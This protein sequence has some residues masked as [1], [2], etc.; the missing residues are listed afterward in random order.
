MD[1]LDLTT[2]YPNAAIDFE[3]RS[4]AALDRALAR[5]GE[6]VRT[7][8]LKPWV[9]RFLERRPE[10]RHL[11]VA[12]GDVDDGGV[13]VR[14]RRYAHVPRLPAAVKLPLNARSMA[15]TAWRAAAPRCWQVVHVQGLPIAPA[16][17][18]VAR[19]LEVPL[20]VTLRDDLAHLDPTAL[21]PA[22]S[23]VFRRAAAFFVIG[24]G[25]ERQAP[26]F[27]EGSPARLVATPNGLDLGEIDKV[28]DGLPESLADGPTRIV[29]VANLYRWKGLHET[30]DA[31]AE[32]ARRGAREWH[33]TVVGD[34]PYRRELE[35]KAA[36]LGIADQVT[37]RGRLAHSDAL[38]EMK[39]SDLFVLPSFMEAF[40][41]VFAEAAAC[42]VP[43]IGCL[44]NG[45]EW[46][47][48]DHKTGLLV[49]PRDIG[50]LAGAL[51]HLLS[52]PAEARRMGRAARR[53]IADFTWKRTAAKYS[54]IFGEILE[55]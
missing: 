50:A 43:A 12:S 48:E 32:V 14:F 39:R 6:R 3:G 28:V 18:R 37:F 29:S 44:D 42:G 45:P 35:Q 40:G 5:G 26:R 16:A 8:V 4:V 47:V 36:E 20:A 11:A 41:N 2:I 1:I 31:L 53:R 30:L 34:G 38:A 49:P 22:I 54:R 17:L 52:H 27:L 21:H 55:R 51:E 33:Y 23:D 9:P 10:Y 15:R 19:R 24:P 7:V 25:L 46:I 13:E